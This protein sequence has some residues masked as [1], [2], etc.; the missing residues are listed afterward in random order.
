MIISLELIGRAF[1]IH[2]RS[3]YLKTATNNANTTTA[4]SYNVLCIASV[5]YSAYSPLPS[6]PAAEIQLWWILVGVCG[7]L[8][9]TMLALLGLKRRNGVAESEAS[10]RTALDLPT[11]VF[12]PQNKAVVEYRNT[13]YVTAATNS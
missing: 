4:R 6:P 9:L 13:V 7:P 11:A 1:V 5:P 8:L 3:D 10:A 12:Q 2:F